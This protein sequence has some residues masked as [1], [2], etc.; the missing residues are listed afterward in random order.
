MAVK[1][2]PIIYRYKTIILVSLTI[3]ITAFVFLPTLKYGF[4]DYDD[5]MYV[6]KNSAIR[7][8]SPLNLWNIF[9]NYHAYNYHPLALLSYAIEYHFFGL[10]PHVYHATNLIFHL[11]NCILVFWLIYITTKNPL[12]S[13]ITAVLFGIH[14]TRVESV[15]WISERR[16]VLYSFFFLG[17]LIFYL[18]YHRKKE[19]SKPFYYMSLISFLLAAFSKA[20][21]V[22][23]PFVMLLFDYL[24]GRQLSLFRN[25]APCRGESLFKKIRQKEES[26][27]PA[28]I[29]KIPFFIVTIIFTIIS[30]AGRYLSG[31]VRQETFFNFWN[32]YIATYG[33]VIYFMKM[34]VPIGLSPINHFYVNIIK[35]PFVFRLSPFIILSFV[36]MTAM[37]ARYT[38]KAI[39]GSLFFLVTILPVIQVLRSHTVC[40]VSYR[41]LYMPAVGIFYIFAEFFCWLQKKARSVKTAQIFFVIFLAVLIGVLSVSSARKCNTWKNSL[42]FWADIMACYPDFAWVYIARAETYSNMKEYQRAI[43]DCEL[44]IKI[45]PTYPP[46]HFVMGNVYSDMGKKKEAIEIYKKLIEANP[47]YVDAY[48]NLASAYISLGNRK[49]AIDCYRTVIDKYINRYTYAAS[50]TYFNLYMNLGLLHMAANE[51]KD[52]IEVYKK[53]LK[54]CPNNGDCHN[55]IAAAYYK[56]KEY[57]LAVKHCDKALKFGADVKPEFLKA[58]EPYRNPKRK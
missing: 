31:D 14:P 16:D 4:I 48:N 51:T 2:Y 55:N 29:E 3:F 50:L 58:L 39:F 52:A 15:V 53:A 47:D 10:N 23:L 41:Y 7:D 45:D 40:L 57:E 21:A 11:L 20:M 38:K 1:P 30:F 8:L 13:F 49:E 25:A 27:P 56:D 24:E 22:S 19:R 42:N 12:I 18:Y 26:L 5:W 9:T 33:L 28:F 32:I 44:A 6:S 17:A 54:I 37:S 43:S 35:M 46:A 34:L 36:V